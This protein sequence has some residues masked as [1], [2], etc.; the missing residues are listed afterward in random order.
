M[1]VLNPAG[2]TQ[3]KLIRTTVQELIKKTSLTSH[4]ATI[5]KKYFKGNTL[6]TFKVAL[7]TDLYDIAPYSF[8]IKTVVNNNALVI[9]EIS[10]V[11]E[12]LTDTILIRK[13]G[14]TPLVRYAILMSKDIKVDSFQAEALREIETKAHSQ[15]GSEDLEFI[16]NDMAQTILKRLIVNLIKSVGLE[17]IDV[18]LKDITKTWAKY[19]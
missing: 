12:S 19:L 1:T 18:G 15:K 9:L 17:D 2:K 5:P 10:W 14:I 13:T 16:R 3:I 11:A 8:D 6:T 4:T 7:L